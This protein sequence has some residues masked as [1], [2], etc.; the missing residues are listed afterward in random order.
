[1]LDWLKKLF[2]GEK[3]ETEQKSFEEK[4]SVEPQNDGDYKNDETNKENN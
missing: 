4:P 2:G 1:M 3:K